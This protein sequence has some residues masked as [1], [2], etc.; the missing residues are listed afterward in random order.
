VPD[1]RSLKDLIARP[2]AS[3]QRIAHH[4]RRAVEKQC[5]KRNPGGRWAEREGTRLQGLLERWLELESAR[6]PFQVEHIEASG[7]TALH[8]GLAYQVRIDRI[9]RLE[10]GSRVLID[11][12]TGW[13]QPDWRGERPDNPQ[14]PMYALLHRENLVAVAYGRVSAAKC[15]FVAESPR[16][17]IFPAVRASRLEGMASFV[18]LVA[19]WERRVESLAEEFSRGAAEVAPKETACRY[20]RLQGLCRVPSTLDALEPFAAVVATA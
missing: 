6:A 19:A 13:V 16:A 5:V 10:D 20:C 18:E 12:K 17:D 2:A 3:A 1:S 9:D 14:L 15:C 4:V 7:E 11:Y 8:G